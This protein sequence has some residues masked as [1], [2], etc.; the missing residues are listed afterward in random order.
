VAAGGRA[1][2]ESVVVRAVGGECVP[3]DANADAGRVQSNNSMQLAVHR[4]AAD[5]ERGQTEG[6][7]FGQIEV[8]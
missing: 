8:R 1:K 7:A 6:S 2:H 5:A 3:L 4:A